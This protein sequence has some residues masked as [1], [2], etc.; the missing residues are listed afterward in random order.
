ML[1]FTPAHWK[2]TLLHP[3]CTSG[4]AVLCAV[5]PKFAA[6]GLLL[7]S[8]VSLQRYAFPV[9][10]H[11]VS[12]RASAYSAQRAANADYVEAALN[13][14]GSL[15]QLPGSV[16]RDMH[17]MQEQQQRQM[18][19]RQQQQQQQQQHQQHPSRLQQQAGYGASAPTSHGKSG[20]CAVVGAMVA[21]LVVIL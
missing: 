6:A 16:D 17:E 18:Q 7:L 13:R 19:E 1:S 21:C 15:Q 9:C 11:H 2:V 12:C 3:A 20:P 10:W 4:C 14:S 8:H 5:Q